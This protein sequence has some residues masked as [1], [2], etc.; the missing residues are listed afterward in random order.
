MWRFCCRWQPNHKT[1]T[2]LSI[3]FSS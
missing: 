1:A 3:F 2:V